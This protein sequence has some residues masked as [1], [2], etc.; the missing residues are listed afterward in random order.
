MSELQP[1]PE[2]STGPE[3][4]SPLIAAAERLRADIANAKTPEGAAGFERA[5]RELYEKAGM[6]YPASETPNQDA[7]DNAPDHRE[8]A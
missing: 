1:H 5:A 2:E 8:A 7:Q 4:A 3:F 6:Q